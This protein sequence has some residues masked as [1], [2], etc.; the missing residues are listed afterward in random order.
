MLVETTLTPST[1]RY[2]GWTARGNMVELECDNVKVYR[3]GDRD[4]NGV[5]FNGILF[6]T[7]GITAF[8]TLMVVANYKRIV[9][10][11]APN[12]GFGLNKPS[13]WAD[14]LVLTFGWL[15]MLGGALML[16]SWTSPVAL[17]RYIVGIELLGPIG[18]SIGQVTILTIYSKIVSGA[19]VRQ[20]PPATRSLGL[21]RFR[22]HTQRM[23]MC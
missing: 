23:R 4:L 13:P 22:R 1:V 8:V 19:P 9:S 11:I 2:F 14:R 17:Y 21:L 16:F 10:R 6:L 20:R 3:N 15:V 5:L 18:Y 12:S 7:M